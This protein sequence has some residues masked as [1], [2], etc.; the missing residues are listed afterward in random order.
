MKKSMLKNILKTAAGLLAITMLLAG[1]SGLAG[2]SFQKGTEIAEASARAENTGK[3]YLLKIKADTVVDSDDRVQFKM[4]G[5]NIA[6]GNT[7]KFKIKP[8]SG[9]TAITVRDGAGSNTKWL[10]DAA[11][12][13]SSV[14][15]LSGE[16][17]GF[18]E[19]TATAKN[20][21]SVLGFTF[22]GKP[23]SGAYFYIDDLVIGK[24]TNNFSNY[25]SSLSNLERWYNPAALSFSIVSSSTYGV[26]QPVKVIE[27]KATSLASSNSR[28]QFYLDGLDIGKDKAVSFK[29]KPNPEATS[30]TVRGVTAGKW[31]TD[32]AFGSSNV[33]KITSGDYKNWYQVTTTAK[34]ADTQLAFTLPGAIAKNSAVYLADITIGST[35]VDSLNFVAWYEPAAVSATKINITDIPA[36]NDNPTDP[37]ADLMNKSPASDITINKIEMINAGP[38]RNCSSE[39]TVSW[40]SPRPGNYIEYS[41]S[42]SFSNAKRVYVEGTKNKNNKSW[43][44]T[45]GNSVKFYICK[46]YLNNLSS[47]TT[48]YYRVANKNAVSSTRKFKTAASNGTFS[49]AWMSDLHTPQSESSSSDVTK[50]KYTPN[51]QAIIDRANSHTNIDF[52]MFS[53]DMTNVGNCYR[54]WQC[55]DSLSSLSNYMY[56]LV[57]GNHDYYYAS[58]GSSRDDKT[59]VTCEWFLDYAAIPK[60][61]TTTYNN[62]SYTAKGGCYWF[63]YNKVLF[64]NIDSTALDCTVSEDDID[65]QINWFK[66]VFADVK[67]L[68]YSY[69]YVIVQQHHA[70][71]VKDEIKWG[72]YKKWYPVFDSYKVDLALSADSHDYSRS[73]ELYNDKEVTTGGTVYVTSNQTNGGSLSSPSSTYSGSRCAFFGGG[74]RSGC[75]ITVNNSEL[76]FNLV[77]SSESKIY[78]T[79]TIKKKSR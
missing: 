34:A 24:T 59:F 69:N 17:A 64:I 56:A 58:N 32:A 21:S 39:M 7:I 77:G 52:V 66:G 22:T 48:Y 31:L 38:G 13:S 23:S 36:G 26:V 25:S 47:G 42:S 11:L 28:F 79:V 74:G 41:T 43:R 33:T 75:Y 20:G 68:G 71:L 35:K 18:Y 27:V 60:T 40:F 70:Y 55:W 2:T 54:H 14:K 63:I 15:K 6:E 73:Y 65:N 72:N 1:C 4:K 3:N 10:S 12:G 61:Q 19:V 62:K 45:S 9:L 57:P 76:T 5:V 49:F 30:L 37:Y 44:D 78:D 67:K 51:I 53:G 46:V 16:W 29:I 50:L 8:Y